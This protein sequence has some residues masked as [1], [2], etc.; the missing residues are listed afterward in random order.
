MHLVLNHNSDL[1]KFWN[2]KIQTWANKIIPLYEIKLAQQR[3]HV[4]VKRLKHV[5]KAEA[6]FKCNEK[7][8]TNSTQ[9]ISME[10]LQDFTNL[11]ELLPEQIQSHSDDVRGQ[12]FILY[13]NNVHEIEEG[14]MSN[15][16][17]N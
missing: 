15:F 11:P 8:E 2:P 7:T 12:G 16:Y 9:S 5:N 13:E 4:L 3:E 6:Y 10:N 14:S 1:V 17:R